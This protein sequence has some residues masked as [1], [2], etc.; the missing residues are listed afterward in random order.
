[1][2]AAHPNRPGEVTIRHVEGHVFTFTA[3]SQQK[4]ERRRGL[5]IVDA[6]SAL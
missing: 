6:S 2:R 5:Q 3:D 1:V 4:A